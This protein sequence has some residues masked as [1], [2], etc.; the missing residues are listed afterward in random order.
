M[1][2]NSG[3]TGPK[4]ATRRSKAAGA[5][6]PNLVPELPT[7]AT[8]MRFVAIGLEGAWIG[9]LRMHALEMPVVVGFSGG[10]LE[11]HQLTGSLDGVKF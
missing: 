7:L 6:L 10:S 3:I 5:E 11:E 4:L 8:A 1:G 2:Q 9:L